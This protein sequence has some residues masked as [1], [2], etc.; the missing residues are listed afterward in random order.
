MA[1]HAGDLLAGM[2]TPPEMEKNLICIHIDLLVLSYTV[3]SCVDTYA[4]QACIFTFQGG[5]MC[6]VLW[7]FL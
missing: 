3:E 7:W 2:G 1:I 5:Y 4:G 6:V